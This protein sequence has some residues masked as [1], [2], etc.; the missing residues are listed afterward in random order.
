M[1]VI[2]VAHQ[3]DSVAYRGELCLF[4]HAM[5]PDRNTKGKAGCIFHAIRNTQLLCCAI[6]TRLFF[7][8]THHKSHKR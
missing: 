4:K 7:F 6:N 1:I 3:V 2:K 5:S 8:F